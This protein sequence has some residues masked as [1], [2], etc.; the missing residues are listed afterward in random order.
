MAGCTTALQRRV[1]DFFLDF[2]LHV[3]MAGEA[4]ISA[5]FNE[6]ARIL[7]LMRIMARRAVARGSGTMDELV[8]Y[9]V[10]MA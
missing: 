7:R 4:Q 10:G 8:V 2:S 6:Q 1:N 9:L 3:D 5:L